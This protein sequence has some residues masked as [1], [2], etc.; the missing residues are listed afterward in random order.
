MCHA[1][2]TAAGC[3][4]D[5]EYESRCIATKP[6]L[7]WTGRA[8]FQSEKARRPP[9]VILGPSPSLFWNSATMASDPVQPDLQSI[10]N[11]GIIAHIDAGKTTTTER[12]LYYTGE[13]DRLPRG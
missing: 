2:L 1:G 5:Q 12:I 6:A 9:S 13:I 11:I 3:A 7:S 4:F 10:R 8:W